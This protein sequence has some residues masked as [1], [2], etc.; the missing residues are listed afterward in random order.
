MRSSSDHLTASTSSSSSI[1]KHSVRSSKNT[2]LDRN[3]LASKSF[4][5]GNEEGIDQSTASIYLHRRSENKNILLVI[6]FN[7]FQL[8]SIIVGLLLVLTWLRFGVK[9][10]LY[11]NWILFLG[12]INIIT[13]TI[14]ILALFWCSR[15]LGIFYLLMVIASVLLYAYITI[16]VSTYEGKFDTIYADKWDLLSMQEKSFVESEVILLINLFILV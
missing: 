5:V 9:Y 11:L 10:N 6:L 4:I 15:K 8:I 1:K 16:H 14:G 3:S 12:T 2:F 13:H 7:I